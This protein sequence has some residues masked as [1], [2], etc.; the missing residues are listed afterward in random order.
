MNIKIL[1]SFLPLIA[2]AAFPLWAAPPQ[3]HVSGNQILTNSGCNVRLKGVNVNSLE[4]EPDGLKGPPTGGG[5]TATVAEAVTAWNAN[6]IRLPLNQDY[7]F[8][9]S[10]SHVVGGAPN[11]TTYQ[12]IVQSIVNYCSSQNVYVILDLHWS[13][14]YTGTPAGTP[15]APCGTGWG[16]ATGQ[17]YMPDDNSITFW[18]SVAGTSWVQNNP[19]VLFDLYNEPYDY[20]GDGWSI[21]LNGGTEAQFGFHTPGMQ[22]LLNTV[23]SAGATNVVVAGGL[24]YAYNLQ[25]LFNNLCS[26]GVCALTDN[27]GAGV[28]YSSHI[29]PTKGNDPWVPSNGDGVISP[30]AIYYPVIVGEFGQGSVIT[31][32][33]PDPDTNGTWDQTLLGWMN[34]SN[35]VSY[36]FNGTAW[37]MTATDPPELLDSNWVTPTSYHGVPVQNWLATAVPTCPPTATP[38]FTPT[39]CGYPGN[40]CTPTNTF[41]PTATP[42]LADDI[43]WPNPWNGSQPVSFYHTL[44]TPADWVALKVYTLSFRKIYENDTLYSVVGH[45]TYNLTWNQVG[46]NLANGLYYLDIEEWRGNNVKRTILKLLVER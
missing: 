32:Y 34:G 45:P 7:W 38:S 11:E 14:T 35:A 17:Q 6:I 33:T 23:R 13:G 44:T 41:T 30:A 40:T 3:L 31:G 12:S 36:Q 15:D 1:F 19:A 24:D 27:S 16:E 18:S 4:Y 2:L 28:I 29:Y 5:I 22:T 10:N 8:G 21:W 9:C 43:P 20:N 42:V 46:G 26:G 37:D 25:G 39:P